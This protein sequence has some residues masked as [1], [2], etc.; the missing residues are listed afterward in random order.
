[1]NPGVELYGRHASCQPQHPG[2]LYRIPIR[3][4]VEQAAK[5]A[6]EGVQLRIPP[7]KA[8]AR[9]NRQIMIS[10]HHKPFLLPLPDKIEIRHVPEQR[11]HRDPPPA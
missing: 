7:R 3:I 6:G 10:G 4:S 5:K 8:T 11:R 1:M 2:I 9:L